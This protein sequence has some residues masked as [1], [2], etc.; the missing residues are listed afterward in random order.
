[1][2]FSAD[3]LLCCVGA[4]SRSRAS[5][6]QPVLGCLILVL[7]YLCTSGALCK[8]FLKFEATSRTGLLVTQQRLY[9]DQPGR[10]KEW[11]RLA[12]TCCSMHCCASTE[13]SFLTQSYELLLLALCMRLQT[14]VPTSRSRVSFRGGGPGQREEK[15]TPQPNLRFNFSYG[16]SRGALAWR[17]ETA[18]TS[19]L[20]TFTHKDSS[21]SPA[22]ALGS[23]QSWN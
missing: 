2:A 21:D 23:P 16:D 6:P 17:T 8:P 11:T 14:C 4:G 3:R 10:G 9:L 13:Y 20:I 18:V 7:A 12:V 19:R 1:M 15:H 5:C 22:F